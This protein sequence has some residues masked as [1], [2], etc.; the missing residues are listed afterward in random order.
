MGR[1]IRAFLAAKVSE[2]LVFK[3]LVAMASYPGGDSDPSTMMHYPEL[4]WLDVTFI[5]LTSDVGVA[6]L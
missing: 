4:P 3:T 5:V 2:H 6:P 1:L